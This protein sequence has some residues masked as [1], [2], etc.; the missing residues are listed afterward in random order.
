MSY[1]VP[2]KGPVHEFAPAKIN[3]TLHVTGQRSDGYHLLDSLVVFA[4]FGDHL[5]LSLSS[6]RSLSVAGPRA[7]GVPEDQRNLVIKAMEFSK[8]NA[9]VHLQKNL[10]AAAGIGGGSSDAAAALRGLARLYDI[11][12]PTE[13]HT[14][15]ADVPVCLNAHAARIQGIGEIIQPL[16]D[17][18]KLHAV[19][20]NPGVEVPTPTIFK[21]LK[22]RENTPM[23]D[24]PKWDTTAALI[25]W[26]A[27]MRNDLETPA[28]QCAPI[29]RSVLTTLA[30]DPDCL[31]ARMSGS[32]ATCFALTDSRTK[33]EDMA[34]R[35]ARPGWWVQ[36]V[37]LS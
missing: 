32:G 31:L 12:I 34:N 6:H 21:A 25:A 5:S 11:P 33:A 10:P 16:P 29:I 26:V 8:L 23:P 4:D 22:S 1:P 36:P 19:L 24:L 27:R 9:E 35:L 17:L 30:A 37:T 7:N 2:E 13:P 3:L 18:P 14:L 20:V 28:C 15:G